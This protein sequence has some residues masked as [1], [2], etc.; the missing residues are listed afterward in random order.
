[1][2]KLA[3]IISFLFHPTIFFLIMPYMLVF[4]MTGNLA[5]SLKWTFFSGIFVFI[6]IVLISLGKRR[7]VFSDFDIS[8]KEERNKFYFIIYL[9]ALIYFVTALFFKGV[10]FPLSIVVFGLIIGVV[11][12]DLVNNFLKASI[13]IGVSCA[14][15]ISIG[16][17][18]G[19]NAFL[20]V[21]WLVPLLFWSRIILQKHTLK[22]GLVGGFLGSIITIIT[23]LIGRY[24]HFRY[25]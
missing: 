11:I 14:Y 5:M 4:K 8:K 24:L 10:F 9:L 1:M 12:F 18:F 7:G 20:A 13:H 22:E 21:V 15:V 2:K 25:S 19:L 17:L 23:F 16:F 6:A 3:K